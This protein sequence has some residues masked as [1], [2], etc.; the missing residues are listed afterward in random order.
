MT[1]RE[2]VTEYMSYAQECE[3]E[4][5]ISAIFT[6]AQAALE[7]GWGSHAPGNNF[8]G[9]KAG[10]RWQGLTQLLTTREVHTTATVKYPVVVS[11]T[12][13]PDGKYEYRVKDWFRAYP[14][15]KEGFVDHAKFF[16]VNKRYASALQDKGDPVRFAQAVAAAG[17]ATDPGYAG[18]LWSIISSIKRIMAG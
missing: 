9:V 6:L 17:Y 12:K 4:T 8:F 13:R 7:S 14:S 11:I 3:A 15:A 1:P 10:P 18:S 2:F 5:G 16:L